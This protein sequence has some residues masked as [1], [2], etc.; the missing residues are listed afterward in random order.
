M[1][2]TIQRS[3]SLLNTLVG[4]IGRQFDRSEDAPFLNIGTIIE[5]YRERF[6]EINK[7]NKHKQYKQYM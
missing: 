1:S 3:I 4:E 7:Q 6:K 5:R 2:L